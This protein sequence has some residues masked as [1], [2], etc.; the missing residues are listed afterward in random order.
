MKTYG[1]M[2]LCICLC[3]LNVGKT[4]AQH[5]NEKMIW[6]SL[7]KIED[8]SILSIQQKLQAANNLK[9]GFE[10]L[11]VPPDSVY[12]RILHR[13]GLYRYL[14]NNNIPDNTAI[15]YTRQAAAINN[16]K[17][18]SASQRFAFSSYRNLAL[19]YRALGM[20][21]RAIHYFD[22]AIIL[23]KK[24][25]MDDN[26]V[27]T[28]I[29]NKNDLL[30]LN[31]DHQKCVEDATLA[32]EDA[33]RK[34]LPSFELLFYNQRGQSNFYLAN[35]TRAQNDADSAQAIATTENN[36]YELAT[37]FKTKAL[38]YAYN[39]EADA[40]RKWFNNCV[41]ERNK[42]KDYAQIADD[43]IDFGNYYFN[44][45][46]DLINAA[47]FYTTARLN[48]DMAGDNEKLAKIYTNL[49]E[50]SFAKH[51]YNEAANY[52]AKALQ[53]L[54]IDSSMNLLHVPRLSRMDMR[55]NA[56]LLLEMLDKKIQL[57]LTYY[58]L[59]HDQPY[60]TSTLEHAS[61]MDSL[62]TLV[63]HQQSGEQ[64]KL[65]WRN[66]TQ[67]FYEN[68][69]EACYFAQNNSRAFFFIEKSRAVLLND[70]LSEL[71]ASATLPPE[72]MRNQEQLQLTIIEEQQKLSSLNPNSPEN[73]AQQIKLL[74]AKEAQD[75]YLKTLEQKYPAYYQYKYEDAVP[76]L[77]NLQVYLQ[78]QQQSFIHYF[79]GDSALYVL[80]ITPATAKLTRLSDE[81][82]NETSLSEYLKMCSDKSYLNKH[83]QQFAGE[84]NKLYNQLVAPLQ[85]PKGRIIICPGSFM[86]PFESLCSDTTGKNFL[87]YDYSVSYVY[88]ARYLLKKQLFSNSSSNG[89]FLGIAPV[90]F[91]GYLHLA[92]LLSSGNA[93]RSASLHYKSSRL[94][95]LNNASHQNFIS[96]AENYAVVN[97]FSHARADSINEPLL[98]LN[99]SVLH[100]YELQLINKPAAQLVVLSACQTNV[101]LN[102]T[103]EG[104]YSLA[105]GFAAT[106]IPS[107]SATLWSADE[108]AIY[109]ITEKFHQYLVAGMP[110]DEA[111]RRAKLAY[112]QENSGEKSLPYYWAN[113]VLIGDAT[114]LHLA[115]KQK[116]T[117]WPIELAISALA[118]IGLVIIVVRRKR[119]TAI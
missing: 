113:M 109:A 57:L 31:G 72:E 8:D 13:I 105:R 1:L 3:L 86:L 96:N 32:L 101:G 38:A 24:L 54:G 25:Q 18:K 20:Y 69:I 21:S 50:V 79:M 110:K 92:S 65:Y 90:N 5:A 19:Y 51:N 44:Q 87:L 111:L 61:V 114:P 78:Q 14:Q 42:T 93:L 36:S 80:A 37:A 64:S 62:I 60:L 94:L 27:L 102:A 56:D 41:A 26:A 30:F 16:S 48:A 33:K 49:G 118:L 116:N 68:A 11:H 29:A 10:K 103:G 46:K 83:Y 81:A 89:D 15:T 73:E 66:R 77:Q 71:G 108:G 17:A 2:L 39:K 58:K 35:I 4:H 70:R 119:K 104:I 117:F 85:L 59:N 82:V 34:Q 53:H 43:Y 55:F 7:L 75:Q 6:D 99:D 98:Y 76:T 115:G 112:M 52:Y 9:A 45:E 100:L 74:Q 67:R 84:S 88:S 40:A 47:R 106:G 12:A 28:S 91:A 23:G 95:L 63:R 22:S 97:V 107:I